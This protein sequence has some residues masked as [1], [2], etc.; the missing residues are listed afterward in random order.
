MLTLWCCTKCSS[1]EHLGSLNG[2]SKPA[3]RYFLH[4]SQYARW[5][6]W[7]MRT[8][9]WWTSFRC[10]ITSWLDWRVHLQLSHS[11]FEISMFLVFL[12]LF[13]VAVRLYKRVGVSSI[14]GRLLAS[15]FVVL[16]VRLWCFSNMK[17]LTIYLNN[18]AI[19]KA[20]C[21]ANPS[22]I[23]VR[24]WNGKKT[25]TRRCDAMFS[26]IESSESLMIEQ[27]DRPS[28]V[29]N[30]L[31]DNLQVLSVLSVPFGRFCATKWLS[32]KLEVQNAKWDACC[33][34]EP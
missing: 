15:F 11:V 18:F 7:L 30:L 21:F 31:D 25:I 6:V 12:F 19:V 2:P 13:A 22:V 1:S 9:I 8:W 10:F 20:T 29:S 24:T 32:E 5:D 16:L 14:D 27:I 17:V 34:P 4:F 23:E 26:R 3:P 28:T 33:E